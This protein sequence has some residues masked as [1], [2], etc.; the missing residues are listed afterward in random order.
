MQ[1]ICRLTLSYTAVSYLRV[2]CLPPPLTFW[3]FYHTLHT[4]TS[5]IPILDHQCLFHP[6]VS[7]TARKE[8]KSCQLHQNYTRTTKSLFKQNATGCPCWCVI[9]LRSHPQSWCRTSW[10]LL[11][12]KQ[13]LESDRRPGTWFF[14][15]WL[16]RTEVSSEIVRLVFRGGATWRSSLGPS[17]G[18][19]SPMM[20]ITALALNLGFKLR[21][22]LTGGLISIHTTEMQLLL[23]KNSWNLVFTRFSLGGL[24]MFNRKM[25]S[26]RSLH[27]GHLCPALAAVDKD[28]LK[29]PG[30]RTCNAQNPWENRV[31]TARGLRDTMQT[32]TKC[33]F[34]CTGCC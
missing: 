33:P 6:G 9:A 25:R 20:F 28:V 22:D 3:Y 15:K 29:H 5:W 18:W 21:L 12:W 24:R 34:I 30:N 2:L 14:C 17:I 26:L 10:K 13:A 23:S 19:H 16:L 4:P 11:R 7:M 31:P 8:A 27:R 1:F 32:G